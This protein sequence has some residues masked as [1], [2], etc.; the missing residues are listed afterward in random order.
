MPAM[1]PSREQEVRELALKRLSLRENSAHE[2]EIY[3][4]RKEI[5]TDLIADTL[6]T[7]IK[8]KLLDDRR[9]AQEMT[10]SQT[11]R[12]KG[13]GYILQ[14]LHQKGVRIELAEV[15]TLFGESTDHSEL[16]M[17]RKFVERRYP[18]AQE[19]EGELKRAYAAILRRGFSSEIARRAL[20]GKVPREAEDAE[21]T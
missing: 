15:R 18:R 12:D 17:A 10:R 19:D 21:S 13:P 4:K 16:E 20:H 5:P 1:K 3:L 14:K 6:A 7:L 2:L 9:Y 8:E 11:A